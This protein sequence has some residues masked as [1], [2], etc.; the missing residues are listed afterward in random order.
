MGDPFSD[1]DDGGSSA[2]RRGLCRFGPIF[3]R[4]RRRGLERSRRLRPRLGLG[5]R[6]SGLGRRRR[7]LWSRRCGLW[8]R[9]LGRRCGRI[10][11]FLRGGRSKGCGR[12]PMFDREIRDDEEDREHRDKTEDIDKGEAI[13]FR[14]G[15]GGAEVPPRIIAAYAARLAAV[16][17]ETA[18]GTDPLPRG[19]SAPAFH[20]QLAH[21][22]VPLPVLIPIVCI[23]TAGSA[24]FS[25][26]RWRESNPRP[27]V[28]TM[29]LYRFIRPLDLGGEFGRRHP[30]SRPSLLC[31]PYSP[32][33]VREGKPRF[34][35][36]TSGCSGPH[37]RDPWS[38][39]SGQCEICVIGSFV[40][41][42]FRRLALHLQPMTEPTPVETVAPPSN[43]AAGRI[44]KPVSNLRSRLREGLT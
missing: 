38:Q 24:H 17:V 13:A 41:A 36:G 34:V 40:F 9:R 8:S 21:D 5:F 19:G 3:G 37:S 22:F 33:G 6:R 16:Y 44:A 43:S 29:N 42:T 10:H 23:G 30:A 20:G 39:L 35:A 1:I 26:W 7:G 31:F 25:L 4:C 15:R 2:R 27:G 18:F 11:C 12:R 32:T 14:A 28:L